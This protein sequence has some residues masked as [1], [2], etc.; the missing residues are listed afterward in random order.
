SSRRR[1]RPQGSSVSDLSRSS[2]GDLRNQAGDF[3]SR[4]ALRA[5]LADGNREAEVGPVTDLAFDPDPAFVQ[6]EDLLRDREPQAGS[7]DLGDAAL[8]VPLVAAEDA[9]DELRRNP[10]A[11]VADADL[12]V[13]AVEPAG[14]HDLAAIR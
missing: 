6:L 13:L 5:F 10:P 11:V 12:D 9:P 3:C 4:P 2:A 7:E 14:H 1:H 8:L